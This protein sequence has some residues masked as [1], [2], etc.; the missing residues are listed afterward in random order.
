M[1]LRKRPAQPAFS[2]SAILLYRSIF[3]SA[4]LGWC[5]FVFPAK[6]TRKSN[7]LRHEA[8][9]NSITHGVQGASKLRAAWTQHGAHKQRNNSE[10]R[11]F[12]S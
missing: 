2:S 6:C 9:I 8:G 5:F 1:L 11:H 7:Y 12:C 4:S 10:A 3:F